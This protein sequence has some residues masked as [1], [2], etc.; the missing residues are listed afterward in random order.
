MRILFILLLFSNVASAQLGLFKFSTFYVG[1]GLNSTINESNTFTIQDNIL[2]ETSI[3]NKYDYRYSFGFRRLARLNFEHKGKA[4]IDGTETTWGRFR[5][6]LIT[7]LEYNFNYERLRDRGIVY[8]NENYF[9]RYIGNI[10]QLKI[11]SANLEGVD[12]QYNELDIRLKANIKAFKL[13]LGVLYR[14]HK[15]YGL[16][17]FN[18]YNGDDFINVANELGYNN[19]LYFNDLNNNNFQDRLEQSF[20]LWINPQGDTIADN[21][22]EFMKYHYSDIINNYNRNEIKKLGTQQTYSTILGV[23]YYKY[24][25][26]YNVLIWSNIIP[27]NNPVTE[28][29]YSGA[30]DYDLGALIQKKIN[31]NLSFYLEATYL[32]YFKR[33]N[34]NIKCGI[35]YII[36]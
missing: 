35:N 23:S 26:S 18:K 3:D 1:M 8:N 6:S 22:S 27:Y 13:S 7:G 36:I 34:Y 14:F 2:T 12:L 15:A 10:Y 17:P 25:D 29:G 30:I 9:I 20:Y 19:H 31:N 28:Y 21:N 24:N 16:N 4:Y 11:E 33:K 32:N 5:S